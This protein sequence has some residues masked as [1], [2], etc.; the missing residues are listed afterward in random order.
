MVMEMIMHIVIVIRV[1]KRN[2]RTKVSGLGCW[3]SDFWLLVC[4][5]FRF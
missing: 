4:E 2:T 3:V 5:M 1:A